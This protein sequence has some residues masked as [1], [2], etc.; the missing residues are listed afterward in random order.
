MHWTV[1]QASSSLEIGPSTRPQNASGIAS[2][3]LPSVLLAVRMDTAKACAAPTIDVQIGEFFRMVK[4]LATLNLM[5][6]LV[7]SADCAVE[8]G[9]REELN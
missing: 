6:L 2:H 1:D 7:D 9:T 5:D 4:L 3:H 8:G